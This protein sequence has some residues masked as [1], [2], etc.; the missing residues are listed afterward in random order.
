MPPRRTRWAENDRKVFDFNRTC[1][2]QSPGRPR[3]GNEED[4]KKD[5]N[6][7]DLKH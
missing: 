1:T 4:F 6:K 2:K 7:L 3:L 5:F